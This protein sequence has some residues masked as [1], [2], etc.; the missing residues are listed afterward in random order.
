MIAKV[1]FSKPLCIGCT[2]LTTVYAIVVLEE[3]KQADALI[4][5]N[6]ALKTAT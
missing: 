2:V 5:P 1:Q 4:T 6:K 3:N